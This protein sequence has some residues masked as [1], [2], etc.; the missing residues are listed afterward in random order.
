[1]ETKQSVISK[2]A[3]KRHRSFVVYSLLI[4]V[5][6]LAFLAFACTKY[7]TRPSEGFVDHLAELTACAFWIGLLFAFLWRT[8]PRHKKHVAFFCFIL[9]IC[10]IANYKSVKILIRSRMAKKSLSEVASILNNAIQDKLI[11]A[12]HFDE[13]IYGEIAPFLQI[14]T[15]MLSAFQRDSLDLNNQLE[16]CNLQSIFEPI[17]LTQPLLI[18]ECKSNYE[19]A[20]SLLVEYENMVKSRYSQFTT[21]I[22][23]SD[24]AV[25][26]KERALSSFRKS[27]DENLKDILEFFAIR[28]DFISEAKRLLAFMQDKQTT[29]K[30]QDDEM[31][32]ELEIDA[33]VFNIYMR[34][35]L[36]LSAREASLV[37]RTQQEAL[38]KARELQQL[39][40][41]I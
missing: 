9:I 32:F 35:L 17:T 31:I 2:T 24:L 13:K 33:N 36:S 11:P 20:D 15:D 19:K 37:D 1:M 30:Y 3:D 7:Y 18:E 40:N 14:M 10:F 21:E 8:I 5:F 34:N 39:T 27:K 26:L 41:P 25:N 6:S 29:C 4:I 23:N 38:E 28:K 22:E 16:L 12:N